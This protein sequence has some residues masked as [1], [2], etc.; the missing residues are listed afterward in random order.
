MP[1]GGKLSGPGGDERAGALARRALGCALLAGLFGIAPA[2]GELAQASATLNVYDEGHLHYVRS[3]GNQLIDEGHASG[4]VPGTVVVRFTYNGSPTVYADFTIYARA[5][6]ISGHANGRLS[7]PTSA[8]PSSRGAL[9]LSG[10]GGHYAHA[11]GSGELFGV[12][13]RRSY[14]MTVQTRGALA[15]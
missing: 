8:S 5:G 1:G 9:T 7:N 15:Y 14:A 10:G 4:T 13:Y 3:S 6:T 11:H 2:G 12:F